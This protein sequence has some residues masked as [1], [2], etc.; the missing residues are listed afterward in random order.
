MVRCIVVLEAGFWL[1][2][3]YDHGHVSGGVMFLV[4]LYWIPM[5]ETFCGLGYLYGIYSTYARSCRFT[6]PF[7]VVGIDFCGRVGCSVNEY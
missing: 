6:M 4:F 5:L 1:S 2:Y 7:A 3:G